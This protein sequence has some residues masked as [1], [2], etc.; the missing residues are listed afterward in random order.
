MELLAHSSRCCFGSIIHHKS[1]FLVPN[2]LRSMRIEPVV[3]SN[4]LTMRSA[5]R[6]AK[7]SWTSGRLNCFGGATHTS[8]ESHRQSAEN[9][10]GNAMRLIGGDYDFPS[11]IFWESTFTR[12]RLFRTESAFDCH[13]FEETHTHLGN[14][15]Q[16]LSRR[17]IRANRPALEILKSKTR[18]CPL[19]GVSFL[20]LALRNAPRN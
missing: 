15:E 18:N 14:R 8:L 7:S 5:F 11:S 1:C 6:R 4:R 2:S 19:S 13:V 3:A 10:N 12:T 17:E 9:Q 20:G 16:G